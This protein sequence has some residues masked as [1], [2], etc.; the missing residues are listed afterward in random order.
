MRR[1]GVARGAAWVL[2]GIVWL[3]VPLRA[4]GQS[5]TPSPLAGPSPSLGPRITAAEVTGDLAAG[6]ELQVTID[7]TMPGGWEGLHEVDVEVLSGSQLLETLRF[8]VDKYLMSIG[9]S[10]EIVVG[11]GGVAAGE[12][13][14]ASGA[15]VIVT[16][17]AGNFSFHVTAD[18]LK[19]LPEDSRFKLSVT[20]DTGVTASVT[21]TLSAP[22]I[23]F[24]WGTVITVVL[25][26]LLAGGFV[27]NLFASK[28]RPP[29][30]VSVYGSIQRRGD[31]D[32]ASSG[33]RSG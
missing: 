27:G 16:T 23:G 9:N 8:D 4:W 1:R 22:K 33:E 18:V 20:D 30:R 32:R 26:A 14:R 10:A 7:A 13:L 25:V 28:R 21:E 24:T 11:T 6:S 17:G 2:V 15:D 29:P 12:Y 3:G 31:D 19:T 5:A